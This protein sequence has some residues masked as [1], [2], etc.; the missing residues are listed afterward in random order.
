MDLF[1][2]YSW[3]VFLWTWGNLYKVPIF[4]NCYQTD[5]AYSELPWSANPVE[6]KSNPIWLLV[7]LLLS[8]VLVSTVKLKLHTDNGKKND[9]PTTTWIDNFFYAVHIA[10]CLIVIVNC[11]NLSN[12][13]T[14]VAL[15]I[16]LGTLSLMI[17]FAK[18]RD[19][20]KV[21]FLIKFLREN[22]LKIYF[23]VLSAPVIAQIITVIVNYK[24]IYDILT[25]VSSNV[26]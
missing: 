19:L 7:H 9:S 17:L 23:V 18:Y 12:F 3:I 1:N 15:G 5:S 13:S 8:V 16:N 6:S 25:G 2:I 10:F 14:P 24:Q 21:T 22:H 20:I 26:F 11:K 4:L